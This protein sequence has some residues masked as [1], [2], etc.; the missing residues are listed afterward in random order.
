MNNN[1]NINNLFNKCFDY[2]RDGETTTGLNALYIISEFLVL[3]LIELRI[4]NLEENLLNQ[5]YEFIGNRTVYEYENII[6]N[7]RESNKGNK[8]DD[9]SNNLEM[10]KQ[11]IDD[12][13]K[14]IKSCSFSNLIEEIKTGQDMGNLKQI[15]TNVFKIIRNNSNGNSN[16]N[17][18]S[19]NK[20]D[21]SRCSLKLRQQ[22]DDNAMFSVIFSEDSLNFVESNETIKKILLALEKCS[23]EHL[24]DDVIG[25]AYENL[26]GDIMTGKV[27]GQFFSPMSVIKMIMDD[28]IQPQI[29]DG[30]PETIMDITCGSGSF[31][32]SYVNYLKK[33]NDVKNINFSDFIF[34]NEVDRD[35]HRLSLMN[36][37]VHTGINLNNI[38]CQNSLKCAYD[39]KFKIICANP[40]YGIKGLS[41]DLSLKYP[42]IYPIHS[43]NAIILFVQLI[44]YLL[45]ING[46]CAIIL[47]TGQEIS[48]TGKL[49]VSLRKYLLQTCDLKE[50]IYNPSNTFTN[51][52]IKTCV[53]FFVKKRE[54]SEV[55]KNKYRTKEV[56]FYNYDYDGKQKNHIVT[57]TIDE[58]I[59]NNFSLR[60]EDYEEKIDCKINNEMIYVKLE[61]ICNINYGTRITKKNNINGEYPVYG[62][63]DISFHTNTYN[64]EGFNIIISRF[65]VSE[66][67]VRLINGDI[68]LNDSA[69]SLSAKS[70]NIILKYVGYYLYNIRSKIYELSSGL[71]QK[72]MNMDKLRSLM[73]PL[74]SIE[75]QN[76][77]IKFCENIEQCNKISLDYID[78]IN[79][80]IE[81]QKAYLNSEFMFDH[82]VKMEDI[83]AIIS[84][85]LLSKKNFIN[86]DYDVYG[87]GKIIGKHN[88]YNNEGNTIVLVRV[89]N[90]II[91]FVDRPYFLTDNAFSISTVK[92]DA[93][94]KYVYYYLQCNIRHLENL[95]SGLAQKVISKEKLNNVMIPLP[96]IKKQNEIINIC[97]GSIAE[98]NK[99]RQLIK[100]IEDD[101]E[102]NNSLVR[103]MF[104]CG[105]VSNYANND[106]SNISIDSDNINKTD[107]NESI[108][109]TKLPDSPTINK[110]EIELTEQNCSYINGAYYYPLNEICDVNIDISKVMV[111]SKIDVNNGIVN[112]VFIDGLGCRNIVFS[113]LYKEKLN[114]KMRGFDYNL[115]NIKELKFLIIDEN[116][117]AVQ[118]NDFSIKLKMDAHIRDMEH[119]NEVSAYFCDIDI[120]NTKISKRDVERMASFLDNF[121]GNSIQLKVRY[122]NVIF[123][124][125]IKDNEIYVCLNY[126]GYY[127]QLCLIKF[128]N[129]QGRYL[130]DDV[131]IEVERC[132]LNDIFV[133]LCRMNENGETI[134]LN[135]EEM[136]GVK[137]NIG[138]RCYSP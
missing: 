74:P 81:L 10:G 35:I 105:N 92:N 32:I 39:R 57:V 62:G 56:N 101:I 83:C 28:L 34:G 42:E 47:P 118:V 18:N 15:L 26:L 90:P 64:R 103:K 50:V 38:I 21:S 55:K 137:Y 51:T 72:N 30:E 20:N 125:E 7:Y 45:E 27:F 48:S 87:G 58:I 109:I 121:E 40:P 8:S 22:N 36:M 85:D 14:Y 106:M 17:S 63:G 88:V 77:I 54:I 117:D 138:L 89:G 44:I 68:F 65:G 133:I 94:I 31:F 82:R 119:S 11:N 122:C 131:V 96:S 98:C 13:H 67:C 9:V 75:R 102:M 136:Q 116:D 1:I 104:G 86:G 25:N 52:T 71:A 33:N 43:T 123:N 6:D 73:V 135:D 108:E 70:E 16:S 4:D 37:F 97:D 41:K 59:K 46:R 91:T 99:K 127:I 128:E 110:K 107:S 134:R 120:Y 3:R 53:L 130:S 95:Y 126:D 23:F 132:M 61:D 29:I 79:I 66:K 78:S 19:N 124:E 113:H 60:C 129:M 12:L 2:L 115:C 111:N 49:F 69:M 100:S 114:K 80:S 5:R 93:L 76:E 24:T 112:I 84:G